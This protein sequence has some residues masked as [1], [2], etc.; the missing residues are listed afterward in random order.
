[1]NSNSRIV[2]VGT[3]GAGKSTFA[4]KLST[5]FGLKDIEL[6]ALFWGPNWTQ[7][8]E[9]EFR[10]S[11][12]NAMANSQGW[13]VHGNYGKVRDMTWKRATT[14]IWLN[15]SRRLVLWRVLK[16]SVTR[17][18]NREILWS[19]N[20]ETFRKTFLSKDSILL[21][22]FQTYRLRKEQYENLT[23]D[24]EYSHLNIIGFTDPREVDSFLKNL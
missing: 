1:M 19:G 4:R 20:R 21:W 16:R 23:K 6:D 2:I 15:Y 8:P 9:S 13:V 14:L 11:I 3:S 7:A 18:I 24:P 17:I 5:K 12:E 22:S 10:K